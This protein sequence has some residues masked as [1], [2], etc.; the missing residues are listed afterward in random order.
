MRLYLSSFRVG[1]RPDELLALLRGGRQA[2]VICNSIDV[3][4]SDDRAAGVRRELD[5][6][7]G[8]GLEPVDV[9]L[10]H[11]FGEQAGLRQRLESCDLIWVRGGNPFVLRRTMRYSGADEILTDPITNGPQWSWRSS[12][13]QAVCLFRVCVGPAKVG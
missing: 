1:N 6:L 2:A 4:D 11:H 8:L 9:D 5:E 3:Y 13:E 10:R 12:P 7:A